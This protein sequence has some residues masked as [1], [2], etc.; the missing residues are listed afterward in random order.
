MM[1]KKKN[2]S[3][4]IGIALAFSFKQLELP[5]FELTTVNYVL[6]QKKKKE[7]KPVGDDDLDDYDEE[8]K[9]GCMRL[10]CLLFLENCFPISENWGRYCGRKL[11]ALSFSIAGI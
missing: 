2:T 5:A 6:F 8:E 7:F 4:E 9:V 3:N 1:K 11:I 10:L